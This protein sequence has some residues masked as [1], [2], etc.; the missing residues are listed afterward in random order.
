[1][2]AK[3]GRE[4]RLLSLIPLSVK[5]EDFKGFDLHQREEIDW[6]AHAF[7]VLNQVEKDLRNTKRNLYQN[8][9]MLKKHYKKYDDDLAKRKLQFEENF[10]EKLEKSYEEIIKSQGADKKKKENFEQF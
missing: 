5:E 4:E 10:P 8:A 2:V 3:E 6:D 9:D 1:M 7:Q